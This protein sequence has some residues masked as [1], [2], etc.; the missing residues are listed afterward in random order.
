MSL[1]GTGQTPS[2]PSIA[3]DCSTYNFGV[4]KV[5]Q[6]YNSTLDYFNLTNNGGVAVNVTIRGTDFTNA[7]A[8]TANW[9]LADNATPDVHTVGL[10]AGL[11]GGD[12]NIIIRKSEAYNNL[13]VNLAAGNSQL[14]GI[15]LWAPTEINNGD[16]KRATITLSAAAA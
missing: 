9:T 14:W 15:K 10:K 13:V 11:S 6:T 4:V 1:Y 8:G 5:G 12:W 7:T 3:L 16:P 2:E